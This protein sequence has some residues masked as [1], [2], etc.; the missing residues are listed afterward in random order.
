M[1]GVGSSYRMLWLLKFYALEKDWEKSLGRK[2]LR[3]LLAEKKSLLLWDN[4]NSRSPGS[5]PRES[6]QG[7]TIILPQTSHFSQV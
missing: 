7:K 3:A 1:E 2:I 4:L 5:L 6:I